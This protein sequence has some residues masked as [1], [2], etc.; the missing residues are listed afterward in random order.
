MEQ[1][2]CLALAIE[3]AKRGGTAPAILNA[4]NE[5]AVWKFLKSEIGYNEIYGCVA[6]AM[7]SIYYTDDTGLDAVLEADRAARI[8]VKEAF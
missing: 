8:H 3:A 1:T 2:P 7:D 5:V 6:S 4:A